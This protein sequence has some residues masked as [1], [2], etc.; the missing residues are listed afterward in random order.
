MEIE[1]IESFVC[2]VNVQSTSLAAQQLGISQPAI[3]RR[4]QNLESDLG[5]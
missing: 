5:L 2:F 3:T 1:D 4:I